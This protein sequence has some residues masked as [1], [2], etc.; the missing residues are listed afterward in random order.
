MRVDIARLKNLPTPFY[1]YEEDSITH[2]YTQLSQIPNAFGI[3][4]SYAMKALAN[5]SVLKILK[6]LGAKID[7]SSFNEAKRAIAAGFK[8]AD[9]TYTTQ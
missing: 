5:Q 8:P 6:N 7:A 2:Q 4:V 9:I 1:L 3:E